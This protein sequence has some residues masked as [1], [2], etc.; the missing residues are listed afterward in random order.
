MTDQQIVA[1]VQ[2]AVND[3]LEAVTGQLRV[4]LEATWEEINARS[5]STNEGLAVLA[6]LIAAL[7]ERPPAPRLGEVVVRLESGSS[8]PTTKRVVRDGLGNITAIEEAPTPLIP[9]GST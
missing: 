1:L 5:T 2:Q 6:S 7:S 4:A 9:K 3:T 8:Q